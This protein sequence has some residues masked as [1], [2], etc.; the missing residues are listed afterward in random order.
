MLNATQASF[1]FCH[2]RKNQALSGYL[3]NALC[4]RWFD[5]VSFQTMY[6]D[7][8]L[9]LCDSPGLVMPSFAA[10]AAEMVCSGIL[11]IDQLRDH[12][13]PINLVSLFCSGF[14]FFALMY[15]FQICSR[16]PRHVLEEFYGIMMPLVKEYGV[17]YLITP[18][19]TAEEFL[20]AYASKIFVQNRKM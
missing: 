1:R 14:S 4:L 7:E 5:D 16:I 15:L 8:K 6:V 13:P 18:P 19:P 20:N 17:E 10:S 12:I 3:L 11:P 2:A 9:M